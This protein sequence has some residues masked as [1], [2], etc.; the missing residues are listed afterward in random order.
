MNKKLIRTFQDADAYRA[1]RD[2]NR[3]IKHFFLIDVVNKVIYVFKK[4]K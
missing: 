4:G 2:S 3:E 1:W